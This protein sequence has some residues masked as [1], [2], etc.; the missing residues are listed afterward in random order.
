MR[1][2]KAPLSSRDRALGLLSRREHSARELSRKLVQKGVARDE[3]IAVVDEL[4]ERSWQSDDRYASALVRKRAG[5]GYG[6]MRIR[7][8]LAVRG[9]PRETQA[10]AIEAADVDWIVIARAAYDRKYRGI[11][12]GDHKERQKRAGWLAAR[13]FDGATI[14]AVTRAEVDE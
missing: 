2:D 7:A 5:D 12:A 3:A 4:S 14:R 9:I 11:A 10:A 6:P 13:G 8:E 1:K